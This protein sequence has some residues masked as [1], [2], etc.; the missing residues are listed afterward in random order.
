M[1]LEQKGKDHISYLEKIIDGEYSEYNG[2]DEIFEE[3]HVANETPEM[4]KGHV[5]TDMLKKDLRANGDY[6]ELGFKIHPNWTRHD[7]H[8]KDVIIEFHY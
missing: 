1:R 2:W 8:P 7:G 6:M 4:A 3:W 5:D